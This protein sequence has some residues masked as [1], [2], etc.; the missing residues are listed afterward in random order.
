MPPKSYEIA[1]KLL[2]LGSKLNKN[3]LKIC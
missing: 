3:D 1:L 2:Y